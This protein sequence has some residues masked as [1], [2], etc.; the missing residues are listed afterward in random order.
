MS[1]FFLF[2]FFNDT[3]NGER[4]GART[5]GN[6]HVGICKG[7]DASR[8]RTIKGICLGNSSVVKIYKPGPVAKNAT[9][10]PSGWELRACNAIEV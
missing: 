3:L 7:L 9:P 6:I 5:R 8:R 10:R 4:T 1:R 2:F